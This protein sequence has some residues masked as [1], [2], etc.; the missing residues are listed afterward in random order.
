[1]EQLCTNRLTVQEAVKNTM[2]TMG[3]DPQYGA[4]LKYLPSQ[5][6]S[7]TLDELLASQGIQLPERIS[8]L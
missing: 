8:L 1:M 2:A 6:S 3:P 5:S 7:K 4:R